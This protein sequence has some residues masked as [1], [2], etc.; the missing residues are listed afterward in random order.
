MLKH[1]LNLRSRR[2]KYLLFREELLANFQ[3]VF[4]INYDNI[5]MLNVCLHFLMMLMAE[6][7]EDTDWSAS[8][9]SEAEW[10]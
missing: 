10:L 6:D 1:V 4:T 2:F 7:K 8:I 9:Y 5:L 3:L